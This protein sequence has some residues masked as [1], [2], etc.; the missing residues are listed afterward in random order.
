MKIG[1][2]RPFADPGVPI[3]DVDLGEIGRLAEHIG[4]DWLTTGHHTVRPIREEIKGPHTH[5]VPFYQDPLIGAARATA[6]T[7]RLE[8]S[9]G[10]LIMPMKHPVDVAKQV[11]SIDAYSNGRFL[12][13]LGTG[14][15]SRIEIEASGGR[16]E[17]RWDYTME[18][19]AVMKG[20][21]TQDAFAFDGDFFQF[22]EVQMYPRPVSKPHTPILLGGYSDGVLKRVG[23]HCQGW[24]PAYAGTRLLALTE[25]DMTGPEHVKQ[26]RAKIMAYAQEAGR[27]IAH[28]EIGV[29][30]APGD[31]SR[32]LRNIYEDA[33]ADRLAF[34]LPH[35]ESVDDARIALE[36]IA[37]N[38]L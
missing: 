18:S 35:I 19:I 1:V 38:V 31:D 9:T 12:L 4:F 2:S 7:T 16:F 37:Q 22:P 34:S 33:G 11:A 3:N 25:T 26:G 8:V 27:D 10:V 23:Q 6:L 36:K 21:W 15:A 24:L 5:G 14:G 20:L 32:E 28:F 13:G 17:R 30:L 29:I